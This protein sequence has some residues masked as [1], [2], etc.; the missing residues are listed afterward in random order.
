M[1]RALSR[2]SPA[3]PAGHP[4]RPARL[5]VPLPLHPTSGPPL[6]LSLTPRREISRSQ[7]A[8]GRRWTVSFRAVAIWGSRRRR[9][10]QGPLEHLSLGFRFPGLILEHAGQGPGRSSVSAPPVTSLQLSL[11]GP[12]SH[13]A[14]R[15][16]PSPLPSRPACPRGLDWESGIGLSCS[17]T[18]PADELLVTIRPLSP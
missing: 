14:A 6:R 15:T 11:P 2:A 12:P 3:T 18:G 4:V 9:G 1:R 8:G 7:E 13:P 5:P 17:T 10:S 16:T